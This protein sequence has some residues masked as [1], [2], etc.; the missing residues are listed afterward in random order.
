MI[1]PS[2][3]QLLLHLVVVD[4]ECAK[5]ELILISLQ[6]G[7][8]QISLELLNLVLP[9]AVDLIEADHITLIRL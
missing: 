9:L 3:R 1:S 4:L 2:L 6:L 8:T 7:Q 5:L